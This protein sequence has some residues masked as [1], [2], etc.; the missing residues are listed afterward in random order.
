[1]QLER[2]DLV[3]KNFATAV[4]D[5]I[6]SNT[7]QKALGYACVA[8]KIY[9]DRLMIKKK[10]KQKQ[11]YRKSSK[12][13]HS[14]HDEI[15]KKIFK[16]KKYLIELLRVIF[17]HAKFAMFD[18]EGIIIKD[19]AL[20]RS[21]GGELR[22]DIRVLVPLQGIE[23]VVIV[24]SIILEH[25]SYSDRDAVLQVMEYYIE[26]CKARSKQRQRKKGEPYQLI[27]PVILLCC[28]DKNFEPPP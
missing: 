20:I 10:A 16:N 8:L 4:V 24:L 11:N 22:T 15:F 27:I 1:M 25:K 5:D 2:L 23:G 14:P 28:E 21:R 26:E 6:S 3:C 13:R 17:S 12:R 18:L 7:Q 9:V 19:S